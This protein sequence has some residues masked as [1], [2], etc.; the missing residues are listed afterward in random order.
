M[1]RHRGE[2]PKCGPKSWH[3]SGGDQGNVAGVTAHL[4]GAIGQ[5]SKLP[6]PFLPQGLIL[7]SLPTS[8]LSLFPLLA[9]ST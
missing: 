2:G 1:N 8:V 7:V 5:C 9:L 3:D 6:P 4:K